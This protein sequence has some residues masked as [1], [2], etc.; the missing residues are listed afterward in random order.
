M[1]DNY[2]QK[3]LNSQKLQGLVARGLGVKD[4]SDFAIKIADDWAIKNKYE[5]NAADTLRHIL[6]GGLMQ[7]V[8]GEDI[9]GRMGK[10]IARQFI[11]RGPFGLGREGT[12]KESL[13]D[14]DNNN[15]GKVLRQRLIEKEDIS[16]KSFVNEAKKVVTNLIKN[17]NVQDI[18]GISPRLS[19]AGEHFLRLSPGALG[20]NI[21]FQKGGTKMANTEELYDDMGAQMELSGLVSE[22]TDRDPVSGNEI[23]LG[24]TAEGVRDDQTAAISAGE[25]VIPDYAVRYHGLDFY[26][27]SLQKAKQ[28]LGQMEG[29]GLVGNPDEQ[30]IPD[31]T[32]LPTMRDEGSPE[33]EQREF[34]SGGAAVNTPTQQT[35]PTTPLPIQPIRPVSAQPV[36]IAKVPTHTLTPVEKL[37]GYYTEV[38][39]GSGQYNY[40]PP[41]GVSAPARMYSR[42]ELPAHAVIRSPQTAYTKFQ[43]PGAG[44]PG[45]YKIEPYVNEAGNIIYLTT[46]GGKVQ[47]GEPPG[48]RKASPEDLTGTTRR[49]TPTETADVRDSVR[50]KPPG[51]DMGGASDAPSISFGA[52]EGDPS[53]VEDFLSMAEG[54]KTFQNISTALGLVVPGMTFLSHFI[55]KNIEKNFKTNAKKH[56]LVTDDE[57]DKL[58][59]IANET[60]T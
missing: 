38:P 51:T 8:P 42:S 11:N 32:P 10:G 30:T 21:E 50:K 16:V 37:K 49:E 36:P 55:S 54:L 15:F 39:P 41:D 18:E 13:I 57:A 25:F 22:P 60:Q 53:K 28:G 34:Q 7:S 29:M 6:L 26:V 58:F 5:D 47:G 45:G 14:I 9:L 4:E 31:E 1:T 27:D 44:L 2:T 17:K 20:G 19:T 12:D 40:T 33:P 23:P 3:I 48:Y 46:V 59:S 52:S 43:G 24:A 35:I 56:F